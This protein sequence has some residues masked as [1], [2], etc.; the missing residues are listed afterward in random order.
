M[1]FIVLF[2]TSLLISQTSFAHLVE[3]D[4][5]PE[6]FPQ[7]IDLLLWEERIDT[8][9][10]L[11]QELYELY[12]PG[13][14]ENKNWNARLASFQCEY[15]S[16]EV[17]FINHNVYFMSCTQRKMMD[18]S[19]KTNTVNPFGHCIHTWKQNN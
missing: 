11:H 17:D 1:N 15:E 13:D 16:Q 18:Y 2:L 19:D 6:T 14:E 5:L 4:S 7:K 9:L 3:E 8:C 10:A 12:N